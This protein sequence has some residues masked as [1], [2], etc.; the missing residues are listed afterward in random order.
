M[1]NDAAQSRSSPLGKQNV[2]HFLVRELVEERTLRAM[3]AERPAIAV[4]AHVGEQITNGWFTEGF[5]TLD[6]LEANALLQTLS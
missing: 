6:L 5:E 4:V 1:R 2:G 3:L